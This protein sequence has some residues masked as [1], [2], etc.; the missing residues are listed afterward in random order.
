MT[1]IRVRIGVLR[2]IAAKS[3]SDTDVYRLPSSF[4]WIATRSF[5]RGPGLVC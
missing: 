5:T 2:T 1:L 4:L 3:M